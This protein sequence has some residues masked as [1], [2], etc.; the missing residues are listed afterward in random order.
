[1]T[2]SKPI[3][4]FKNLIFG[5]LYI[6]VDGEFTGINMKTKD[7]VNV[8]FI[9]KYNEKENSKILGTVFDSVGTKRAEI[10]GSWL[11]QIEVKLLDSGNSEVM[12]KEAAMVENAYMQYFYSPL[13]LLMNFVSPEMTGIVAPTDSRFRKDIRSYEHGEIE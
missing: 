5:Q 12:W 7:V 10:T 6:D 2:F 13:T 8:K 11:N 3:I 1:M 4:H 9:E